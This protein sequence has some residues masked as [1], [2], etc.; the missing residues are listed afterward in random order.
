MLFRKLAAKIGDSYFRDSLAFNFNSVDDFSDF[1]Q[2][3][4]ITATL[5]SSVI[6][7]QDVSFFAPQIKDWFET[8]TLSGRFNGTVDNFRLN[9]FKLFT[10]KNTFLA[11]NLNMKGLPEVDETFVDLRLK[12]SFINPGDLE[13]YAG[14]AA[15]DYLA[16]LGVFDVSGSF[17]GFFKNFVTKSVFRTDLG[18]LN[19]DMQME[20]NDDLQASEDYKTN[21]ILAIVF[22]AIF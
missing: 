1:N 19:A 13:F 22:K 10:G 17:T 7:S 14:S 4:E 5:D 8:Y 18:T 6:T 2:K 20:I 21:G 16:M 15:A 12:P 3:V 11:G 9:R